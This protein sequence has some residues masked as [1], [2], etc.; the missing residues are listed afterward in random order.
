MEFVEQGGLV[1][2]SNGYWARV[3]DV[4]AGTVRA[5]GLSLPP[6]PRLDLV[7]G[8]LP[9]GA[10]SVCFTRYADGRLGGN[11]Q[12][13]RIS[14]TGGAKGIRLI[15][16]PAD[17]LAWITQPNGGA[18]FLA[19]VGAGGA[20]TSPYYAQPLPTLSVMP[21][22][23]LTC[24]FAFAGR[25]W[26]ASG[27]KLYYSEEFQFENF[28]LANTF[29]FPEDIVLA[30]P[31]NEGV[32]VNSMDKTWLLK[33]ADP[34]KMGLE[35]AGIGAIPGTLVYVRVEG[36]GY[37][38]SK[39]LSQLPSPAWMSPTGI[40]LGTQT[41]HIVYLTENRLRCNT[42]PKGAACHWMLDGKPHTVFTLHG[43]PGQVVDAS[44]QE[45]FSRG[46]IFISA[47]VSQ[48][49]RGGVTFGSDN[50]VA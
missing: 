3:Y 12:V 4:A 37:E 25:L 28:K 15:N 38:I 18:F 7:E 13:S 30:A 23:A 44:L 22:P 35:L 27:K 5:W 1:Y 41:G 49:A 17:C 45:I 46:R 42:K 26:G 6:A 34:A 8:D 11:G 32:Y 48:T 40:V 2:L 14:F 16:L 43:A 39:K 36:G 50:A 9:P 21:P 31:F 47:P 20:I 10:Y 33:G 29:P 19:T 24:L